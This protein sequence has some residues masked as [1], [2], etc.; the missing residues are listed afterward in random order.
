MPRKPSRWSPNRTCHNS[1]NVS[2]QRRGRPSSRSLSPLGPRYVGD[3]GNKQQLDGAYTRLASG[4]A[5]LKMA[6]AA[7]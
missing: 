7:H 3:L 6:Y 4:V 1:P 5:E 2:A